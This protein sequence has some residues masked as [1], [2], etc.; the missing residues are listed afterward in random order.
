M[1]SGSPSAMGAR[2]YRVNRAGTAYTF[3]HDRWAARVVVDDLGLI[4]VIIAAVVAAHHV[5]Q[6]R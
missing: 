6:A 5:R 3:A 4:A 2:G 1:H